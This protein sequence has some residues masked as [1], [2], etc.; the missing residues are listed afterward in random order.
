V[1]FLR[2]EAMKTSRWFFILTFILLTAWSPYLSDQDLLN[3]EYV[4][5]SHHEMQL[6]DSLHTEGDLVAELEFS[7]E[8]MSAKQ[9]TYETFSGDAIRVKGQE[10]VSLS[11]DMSTETHAN[12]QDSVSIEMKM[13][14]IIVADTTYVRF[15]AATDEWASQLPTDWV[16]LATSPTTLWLTQVLEIEQ[17]A[18][19]MRPIT[20]NISQESVTSIAEL[21]SETLIEQE[22]RVFSLSLNSKGLEQ[23]Q[24]IEQLAKGLNAGTL[25][26]D[27][28]KLIEDLLEGASLDLKVWIG[29]K[30]KLVY[31]R[32]VNIHLAAD[33]QTNEQVIHLEYTS[34]GEFSYSNFNTPID[35]QAPEL[36]SN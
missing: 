36:E 20:Y 24:T 18:L 7:V 33:L 29:T 31:K 30:D 32:L 34:A 23:S 26:M 17:L 12:G 13:D 4:A 16:N 14:L 10:D 1:N 3:I 21:P 6:V 9:V 5:A 8:D 35:I 2:K 22:M 15:D 28:D 27:T 11:I 25:N 19:L